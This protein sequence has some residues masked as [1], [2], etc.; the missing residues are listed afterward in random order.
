MGP[1]FNSRYGLYVQM[2]SQSMLGLAGFLQGL[3]FPT[4]FTIGARVFITSK[5]TQG[6]RGA[7]AV[8]KS[9]C[10]NPSA[11]RIVVPKKDCMPIWSNVIL[12]IHQ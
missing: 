11:D 4:A 9:G 3:R 10:Y 12:M 6:Y 1:G 2:V 7:A 8:L 5:H